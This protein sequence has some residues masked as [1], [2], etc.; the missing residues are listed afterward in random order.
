MT[1]KIA[2]VKEFNEAV[3]Q[4]NKWLESLE[5]PK[6]KRRN[7]WNSF[8]QGA[9]SILNISGTFSKNKLIHK[10]PLYFR[11]DISSIQKDAIASASD[12]LRSDK[13][14]EKIISGELSGGDLSHENINQGKA[15]VKQM[16]E[17]F[18]NIYI[19]EATK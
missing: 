5:N 13:T 1:N 3:I 11:N 16:Y 2:Y 14:L 12:C 7:R 4:Y 18:R 8:L 15:Y 19:S 6:E 9:G 17:H 10:N